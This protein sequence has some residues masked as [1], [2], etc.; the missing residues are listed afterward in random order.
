M[1]RN[2][3]TGN[4][5]LSISD[6]NYLLSIE[7]STGENDLSVTTDRQD[8]QAFSIPALL[9]NV[10]QQSDDLVLVQS[11]YLKGDEASLYKKKNLELLSRVHYLPTPG[12]VIPSRRKDSSYVHQYG[13]SI[14]VKDSINKTFYMCNFD[15]THGCHKHYESKDSNTSAIRRHLEDVHGLTKTT[16]NELF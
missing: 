16:G 8:E 3:L 5:D 6:M 7:N 14:K 11:R 4:Y 12:V 15:G 2:Q 9:S 1:Y 10:S 13:H